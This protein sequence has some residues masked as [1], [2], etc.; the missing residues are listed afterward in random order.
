MWASQSVDA[1]QAR[2]FG[3]LKVGLGRDEGIGT[4]SSVASIP[5]SPPPPTIPNH[6]FLQNGGAVVGGAFETAKCVDWGDAAVP[7][8]VDVAVRM[9]LGWSESYAQGDAARADRT[10]GAAL[11]GWK[12]AEV[13]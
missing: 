3:R 6:A 8:H 9:S 4:A 1:S 2:L 7:R 12:F 11:G 5:G 13:I 10:T